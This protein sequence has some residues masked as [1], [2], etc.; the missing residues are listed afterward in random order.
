MEDKQPRA[1][2][3][4]L[5]GEGRIRAALRDTPVHRPPLIAP[6]HP[7]TVYF[8]AKVG[9]I[10]ILPGSCILLDEEKGGEDGKL[11]NDLWVNIYIDSVWDITCAYCLTLTYVSLF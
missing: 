6:R 5:E 4:R 7:D 3:R 8:W 10:L 1:V 11:D 9:E 2:G